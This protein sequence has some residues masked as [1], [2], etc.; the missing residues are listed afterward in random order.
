[1]THLF[2]VMVIVWIMIFNR[3]G[4][5]VSGVFFLGVLLLAYFYLLGSKRKAKYHE[6]T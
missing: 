5:D 4:V 1:M 6:S 2:S 3:L